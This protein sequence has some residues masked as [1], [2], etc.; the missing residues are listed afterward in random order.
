MPGEVDDHHVAFAG[1]GGDDVA[2]GVGD[3]AL[4]GE[5][6]AAE[7]MT[8]ELPLLALDGLAVD[9]GVHWHYANPPIDGLVYEMDL[10]GVQTEITIG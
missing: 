7:G 9:H 10:R 8:D 4:G 5:G 6:H 1:V 3:S 2:D